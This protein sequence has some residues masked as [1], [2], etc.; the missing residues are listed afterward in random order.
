MDELKYPIG[1]FVYKADE[2]IINW[3]EIIHDFPSQLNEVINGMSDQQLDTPYRPD[4]WTAR[5]VIHHLA[6]SHCHA[7]MRFKWTLSESRPTIKPYLENE[8]AKLADY[9]LPISSALLIL[10]G[11]HEKWHF[12]LSKMETTDWEKGY[13]HPQSN[14]FFTLKEAVSL[15]AWH[16][17]HHLG[18]L[19][20]CRSM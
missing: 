20:I 12:I 4:G 9:T 7:L 17:M 15:Y 8:Y 19:K 3:V 6:D 11:V 18:H 14:K 10:A 2:T 1:K 16:C 5:Q 13:D